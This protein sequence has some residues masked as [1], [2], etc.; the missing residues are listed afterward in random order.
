MT[1]PSSLR[2]ETPEPDFSAVDGGGKPCSERPPHIDSQGKLIIVKPASSFVGRV[3][4]LAYCMVGKSVI[5]M[6][7]VY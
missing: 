6:Q 2:R 5:I 1:P 3:P 7:W 4:H